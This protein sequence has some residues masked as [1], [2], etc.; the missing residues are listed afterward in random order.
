MTGVVA[1]TLAEAVRSWHP[2]YCCAKAYSLAQLFR[3]GW[4]NGPSPSATLCG[5]T[6]PVPGV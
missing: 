6:D 2:L 1:A 4:K 3:V 5:L